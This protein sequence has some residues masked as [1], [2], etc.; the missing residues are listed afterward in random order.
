MCFV[1]DLVRG[2]LGFAALDDPGPVNLG[3]PTEL[4]VRQIAE[5][6]VAATG[7][8]SQLT[9]V[10]RP[11]DDPQVRRPDTTKAQALLGWEPQVAWTD[12]LDRTVEWF[13]ELARSSA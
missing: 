5:D 3:N 2:I 10:E 11:V 12:G 6:V 13:A 8:A 9:F 4:T 7:S 1:D